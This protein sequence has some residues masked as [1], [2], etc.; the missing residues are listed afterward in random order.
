M[1]GGRRATFYF[2]KTFEKK[3]ELSSLSTLGEGPT[4]GWSSRVTQP[5]GN[6]VAAGGHGG[7]LALLL[8]PQTEWCGARL[9]GLTLQLKWLVCALT[10]HN[11]PSPI[12]PT[13]DSRGR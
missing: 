3:V 2:P 4:E 7:P 9:L 10:H 8:S 5:T 11:L 12:F 6:L 13:W 1:G